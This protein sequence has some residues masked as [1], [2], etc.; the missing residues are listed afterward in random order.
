MI[1]NTGSALQPLV[2]CFTMPTTWDDIDRGK[3][4]MNLSWLSKWHWAGIQQ[5]DG[6]N[7]EQCSRVSAVAFNYWRYKEVYKGEESG[8]EQR[9]ASI[10]RWRL[11]RWLVFLNTRPQSAADSWSAVFL[12]NVLLMVQLDFLRYLWIWK[13]S[14]TIYFLFTLF[15]MGTFLLFCTTINLK[16]TQCF[17]Y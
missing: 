1:L 3:K 12:V 14:R 9:E 17:E 7:T 6:R 16:N 11:I 8:C 13:S 5:G 2:W 15:K 10:S 4:W